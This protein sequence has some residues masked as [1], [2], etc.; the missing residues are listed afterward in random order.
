MYYTFHGEDAEYVAKNVYETTSVLK[1]WF[2][3]HITG[4]ATT[5][6]TNKAAE[7]FLRD[8]LLNKQL[9]IEI[10]KSNRNEWQIIRKASPG[11]LQDVEDFLFSSTHMTSAPVV[12]AIKYGVADDNKV[13]WWV[14][15]GD[16]E[17]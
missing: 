13:S 2:G 17:C 6:L 14:Q 3:D 5:K 10:W 9:R 12:L 11:N 1:Y 7:S 16:A 4:L 15:T 8:V